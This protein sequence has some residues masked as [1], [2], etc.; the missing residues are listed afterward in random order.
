MVAAIKTD[1]DPH[2][3]MEAF[4]RIESDMGRT[5]IAHRGEPRKID[6]DILL[7]GEKVVTETGLDI[8][9]PRMVGRRF[10]LE[11]LAD[12]APDL[13]IPNEE[14]TVSQMASSLRERHP[15]QVVKQVGRLRESCRKK[16]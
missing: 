4:Q 13:R 11:P 16:Y 1:R 3:L 8:P 14:K 10:V 15:E 2:A 12:L 6:I 5:G 7:Y 9:H